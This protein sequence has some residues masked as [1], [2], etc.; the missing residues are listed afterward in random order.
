MEEPHVIEVNHQAG[1]EG[2]RAVNEKVADWEVIPRVVIR[3]DNEGEER[4]NHK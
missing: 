3:F 2:V 1:I 4:Y